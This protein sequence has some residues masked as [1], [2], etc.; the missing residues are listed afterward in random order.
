MMPVVAPG[1]TP[2]TVTDR[3][4][5]IAL[6]RPGTWWYLSF[7]VASMLLLIGIGGVGWLFL[8]GVQ[9]WGNDWPEV[10]G[11]PI[12]NYVW[13]I[14]IASGGTLISA[15]FFLT[16]SK[17]RT[18]IN[19]IAEAMTI[20]AAVCAGVYP[21]I[22]LGRPWFFYWLVPYPNTMT[23]WP[24]FRSPLLWDF[25]A[26]TA[27]VISSVLFW[28]LG[29]IPDV[30][31]LRDRAQ[32]R[33]AQVFYGIL[34]LGFRGTG[35]QWRRYH[36]AYGVMAAVMAPLVVSVHSVVGLDF[37]GSALPGWYSTQYPPFF[38]FGA[39]LSGFG[40]VL[41]LL[42][43]LRRILGLYPYITERHLDVLGRLLLLCSLGVAYC[44][45]MDA[46]DA[47]YSD[48][49][50]VKVM[51]H[52]RVFGE[53]GWIW[54]L[55]IGLNC[56]LPLTLWARSLRLRPVV[57]FMVGL[58]AFVGMWFE[59]FGIVIAVP[60]RPQLPSAWG[61]YAPTLDDYAIFAGTVGLFSVGF[62]LFVRLL[63]V[64]SI[65]EMKQLVLGRT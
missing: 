12:I 58:G 39:A 32:Q 6:S 43:P 38:V 28:L 18:S 57:L 29:L 26:I 19:R 10:W 22:H 20:F 13:W 23:L 25:I 24:Q 37:A 17:W 51:F 62:L 3:I 48:D 56:L 46:F 15:L 33:P 54:W 31:S 5:G 36:R 47:F 11:F 21:I 53:Y 63:P 55:T 49:K 35:A 64:V 16:E 4:A 41:M 40:M 52:A 60:H 45:T 2:A 59:R 8:H 34:A 27:Y 61:S 7:A 9:V 1:E 42:L 50:A 44:Y 14:G 65:A 30:A